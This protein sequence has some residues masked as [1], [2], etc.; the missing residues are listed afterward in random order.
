MFATIRQTQELISGLKMGVSEV[1]KCPAK[2]KRTE[3]GVDLCADGNALDNWDTPPKGG[4]RP[5]LIEEGKGSPRCCCSA[6]WQCSR[7]F[8]YRALPSC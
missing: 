6:N 4:E 5:T 3:G 7:S 8:G 1:A 2:F